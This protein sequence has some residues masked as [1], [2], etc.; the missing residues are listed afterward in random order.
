MN[1]VSQND[2]VL[3]LVL[4][5]QPYKT[6]AMVERQNALNKLHTTN[7]IKQQEAL[8]KEEKEGSYAWLTLKDSI[9]QLQRR[10]KHEEKGSE[11]NLRAWR[12]DHEEYRRVGARWSNER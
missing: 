7:A 3:D 1:E 8:L 12:D 5:N 10:M 2:T 11:Q 9:A 6:E 4:R